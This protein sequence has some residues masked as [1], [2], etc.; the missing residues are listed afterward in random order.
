MFLNINNRFLAFIGIDKSISYTI[1]A[2]LI[3]AIGTLANLFLI[4]RILSSNEQGY[5]YTFGSIIAIQV[6]FELGLNTIIIQFVAHEVAHLNLNKDLMFEGPEIHKSRL[7]SL[8]HFCIK[9]FIKLSFLL[10]FV[11]LITGYIFFSKY[12]NHSLK[13]NWLN[14]WILLCLSTSLMLI[15]NPIMGFFQGLGMVKDTARIFLIQQIFSILFSIAILYNN[16]GLWALGVSNLVSFL[17]AV[18]WIL[19]T[20]RIKL[21]LYIYNSISIWKINYRKEIFPYQWK[22]AL[23]WI[24]GFFIF[25]LFNPVLFATEGPSVAGKMGM[26]LTALN[27]ISSLSMSWI[28]TKVPLFSNYIAK[29][30]FINLD[31]IFKKTLKRLLIICAI[32]ILIFLSI[33]FVLNF[34]KIEFADRFLSIRYLL[35]LS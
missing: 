18:S 24:S 25:Q 7:S 28:S 19:F 2:R 27:G 33:I 26:S 16:G 31:L 4:S 14:P 29:N 8:L 21:L 30:D 23:S 22:I 11:L 15:I 3:Q 17:I 10:F 34:F 6:F 32:L 35:A 9:I 5:Y 20:F 12:S 13:I 1:T